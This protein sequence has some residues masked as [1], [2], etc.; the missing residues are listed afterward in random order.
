MDCS[1]HQQDQQDRIPS[2]LLI[3]ADDLGFGDLQSYGHPS[4]VTPALN[5]LAQ[6]GR[7]FTSYYAGPCECTWSSHWYQRDSFM[8][9]ATL[10]YECPSTHRAA[11]PAAAMGQQRWIQL[12]CLFCPGYGSHAG[13]PVCS[14]SRS[15][16]LTGRLPP[17]NGVYCASNT[18]ACAH[19][20]DK[21]CCN[22]VF[23][24]GMPGPNG[25]STLYLI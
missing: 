15:V 23:L 5:R 2:V 3:V 7:M 14:P 24:P 25:N 4:S 9:R 18:E 17:R 21:G 11:V 1:A 16:I 22:G 8:R 13:S 10:D 6:E 19:P 20:E 12:H